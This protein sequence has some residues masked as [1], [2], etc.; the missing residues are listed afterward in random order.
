[1]GIG[2]SLLSIVLS[3]QNLFY[4]RAGMTVP[5]IA[6]G[7]VLVG[8]GMAAMTNVVAPRHVPKS[9]MIVAIP[10]ACLVLIQPGPLSVNSGLAYGGLGRASVRTSIVIPTS[11]RVGADASISQIEE[12]AVVVDPGQ[13]LYAAEQLAD[14]FGDVAV[15]M[16][17]QV[18]I[19]SDGIPRLVRFRIICCAADAILLSVKLDRPLKFE[20]GTWVSVTGQ[21]DGDSTNPGIRVATAVEIEQPDNPYLSL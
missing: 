21:W 18:D 13:F 11:A 10:V 1:M 12:H 17:G 19:D 7:V 14:N 2:A 6:A 8:L 5:L 16:I 20:A 9:A 3:G 15:R 4:V